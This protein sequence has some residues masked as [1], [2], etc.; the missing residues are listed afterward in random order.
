MNFRSLCPLCLQHQVEC[1]ECRANKAQLLISLNRDLQELKNRYSDPAKTT[2][3]LTDINN[4]I[5]ARTR[6]ILVLCRMGYR[7][8][9]KIYGSFNQTSPIASAS[10]TSTPYHMVAPQLPL[11]INGCGK[12][13]DRGLCDNCLDKAGI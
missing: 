4:K 10:G 11:I 1:D 12:C 8:Y 6:S 2:E 7:Y 3:E 9:E 13:S 5:M